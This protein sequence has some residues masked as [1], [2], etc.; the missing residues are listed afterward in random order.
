MATLTGYQYAL[1]MYA[2]PTSG[3]AGT[4]SGK[5]ATHFNVNYGAGLTEDYSGQFTYDA[6]GN[7]QGTINSIVAGIN[8]QTALSISGLNLSTQT[9]S[10]Y[11]LS[12]DAQGLWAFMFSGNDVIKGSGL[13]DALF[14]CA[15]NDR[16]F[17]GAGDDSLL[18]QDGNDYLVGGAGADTLT[19]GAGADVLYGGPGIGPLG[20][21]LLNGGVGDDVYLF[22]RG[23]Q[24]DCISSL[25]AN[26]AEVDVIRFGAGILPSDI[27]LTRVNNGMDLLLRVRGTGDQITVEGHFNADFLV[28]TGTDPLTGLPIQATGRLK[29]INS[30]EF[31]NGV[32]W[33]LAKLDTALY[34][35]SSIDDYMR[36][37]NA[38][39][40][41]LYGLAGNDTIDGQGGD[42][43]L[44][45]G[46]G[47]DTLYGGEGNDT[48]LFN[49]GDGQ[50]FIVE[51]SIG[52]VDVIRFGTGILTTDVVATHRITGNLELGI[53]GTS[54]K[55]VFAGI[56]NICFADGTVWTPA[57]F[58]SLPLVGTDLADIFT[59][60]AS[61]DVVYGGL[62]DDYL[63]GNGG[64][65]TLR[66]D[67]G[68]D[69]LSG[70]R[71]NDTYI[72]NKGDGQDFITNLDDSVIGAGVD[73]VRFG[74]GILPGSVVASRVNTDLVLSLVGTTDKVT[75]SRHFETPDDAIDQVRF[76]DG[77]VWTS[78]QFNVLPLLG[79]AGAD[80]ILGTAQSDVING[81]AGDDALSGLNGNDTIYGGGGNDILSG[82]NG[83]DALYGGAGNDRLYG[84]LGSD[85]LSGGA[86]QDFFTFAPDAMSNPDRITD[87]NVADDTIYLSLA[88]FTGLGVLSGVLDAGQLRIAAGATAA[89]TATQHLIYNS[90]SGVL[91][92]DADANGAGVSVQIATLNTGLAL[93]NADFLLV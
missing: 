9:I 42:D 67:K 71:G 56:D 58:A 19:G 10:T 36:G 75:I 76:A 7:P 21:E 30:V 85:V 61:R 92:Y 39:S 29:N 22:N 84:W 48:Y 35:G 40:E 2:A 47:N 68:N 8:G 80:V 59:G 23:D 16:L 13:N 24:V 63:W 79:T 12:G 43:L 1:N 4:V 93:T 64:N 91:Y 45:G 5:T 20:G 88:T 17:G 77:T 18:G 53:R 49:K 25:K 70:G 27:T 82:D 73:V 55:L 34:Q 57:Q 90:T 41:T 44:V 54:D 51:S 83:N 15:G 38:L 37:L 50:D 72:F 89:A 3:A 78:A 86:G 60:G 33:D 81:L 74:A 26:L 6:Q 65:D 69:Y 28:T 52:T 62:G 32:T 14:G 11:A 31:A 46:R 66:G 87:F